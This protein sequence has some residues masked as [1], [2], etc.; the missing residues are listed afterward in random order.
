MVD[1]QTVSIVIASASIVAGIIYYGLQ[2]RQQTKTR[3]TDLILR[4]YT[5]ASSSEVQD[6]YEKMREREIKNHE[7]YKK[8][9]GTFV[10]YNQLV[11]LYC[12]LGMLLYRKLVDIDLIDDATGKTVVMMYEKVKPLYEPVLKAR[13]IE[14]DSFQYLYNEMKKREQQLQRG[15]KSG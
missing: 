6:S 5:T 12:A 7:D 2:I 14:W 9:Y 11:G 10:E 4:L 15:A 8:R 1:V 13:G 3:Q